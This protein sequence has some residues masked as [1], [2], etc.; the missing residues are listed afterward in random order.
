MPKSGISPQQCT[1][2]SFIF[3]A[4]QSREAAD[5]GICIGRQSETSATVIAVARPRVGR[6]G[7]E[8]IGE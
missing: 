7:I 6:V 1:V 4:S 5:G 2:E 8:T 3:A